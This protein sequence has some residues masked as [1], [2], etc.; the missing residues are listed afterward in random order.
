LATSCTIYTYSKE[1]YITSTTYERRQMAKVAN[2]KA[3]NKTKKAAYNAKKRAAKKATN[4]TV[5]I[6]TG[7]EDINSW[8]EAVT[9]AVETGAE[10]FVSLMNGTQIDLSLM[11]ED[12]AFSSKRMNIGGKA[13]K[14]FIYTGERVTSGLSNVAGVEVAAAI[15]VW[16]GSKSVI[17]MKTAAEL[18]DARLD[19][20]GRAV[21]A[22]ND[23]VS[24]FIASMRLTN[25]TPFNSSLAMKLAYDHEG[26]NAAGIHSVWD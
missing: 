1:T 7:A 16:N 21:L 10:E 23:L 17:L 3:I 12:A 9:N 25:N 14:A 22:E 26:V 13:F 15:Q 5:E 4:S 11:G 2:K 18:A 19:Y 8:H 6:I 20:R 24:Q